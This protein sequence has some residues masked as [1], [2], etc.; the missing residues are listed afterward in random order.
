MP[1]VKA[2]EADPVELM[3]GSATPLFQ[4]SWYISMLGGYTAIAMSLKTGVC[5]VVRPGWSRGTAMGLV[6][7]WTAAGCTIGGKM[8]FL[9]TLVSGTSGEETMKRVAL[10]AAYCLLPNLLLSLMA[11]LHGL[12]L[13]A[14]LSTILQHPA[15]I[16]T[17]ALTSFTFG[18]YV[19]EGQVALCPGFSSLSATITIFMGIMFT[20]VEGQKFGLAYVVL[21]QF[22]TFYA[23]CKIQFQENFLVRKFT[24]ERAVFRV[25]EPDTEFIINAGEVERV[26]G[27][28]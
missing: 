15:L 12:D 25:E 28:S 21:G 18:R 19:E 13:C 6:L 11:L 9:R 14:F 24:L 27:D 23:I 22:L 8:V 20:V 3:F 26:G 16:I 4:I 5:R 17:P 1:Q 10:W 7:C 2:G